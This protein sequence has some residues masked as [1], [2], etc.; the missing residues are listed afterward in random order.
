MQETW[1]AI[2]GMEGAY[3]VSDLGRVRSL[4]RVVRH[5]LGGDSLRRGR[6][7]KQSCGKNGY[8][9]VSL[10]ASSEERT[11]K[12]HRLVATHFLPARSPDLPEVNHKDFDRTNNAV[13]NLEWIDREGNV[14]HARV[15]GRCKATTNPK[16]AKKLTLNAVASIRADRIA[17]ATLAVIG[18][19]HGVS[20]STVGKVVRGERWF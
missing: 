10:S 18:L 3:E 7:L 2:E 4:D 17:G 6:I 1:V 19:K 8:P 13:S 11:H 20:G 9:S 14:R 16:R 12:V 15:G 5:C